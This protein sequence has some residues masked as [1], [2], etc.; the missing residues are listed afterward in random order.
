[1]IYGVLICVHNEG[2]KGRKRERDDEWVDSLRVFFNFIIPYVTRKYE[3][4]IV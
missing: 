1:M 4:H 2:E 3:S